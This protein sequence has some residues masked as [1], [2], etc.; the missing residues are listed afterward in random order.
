MTNIRLDIPDHFREAAVALYY[1]AFQSKFAKLITLDEALKI[2]PDLL[3]SE[4]SIYAVQDD[5]LVGFA[6][7]RRS[8]TDHAQETIPFPRRIKRVYS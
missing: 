4:Q 1:E 2:L 8:W 6:G 7:I 3:N 5:Q